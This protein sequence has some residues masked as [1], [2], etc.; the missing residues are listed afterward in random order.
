[1]VNRGGSVPAMVEKVACDGFVFGR[2]EGRGDWKEAIYG[3]RRRAGAR[4]REVLAP[5]VAAV[6]VGAG[7]EWA[8]GDFLHRLSFM[9]QGPKREIEIE[10]NSRIAADPGDRSRREVWNGRGPRGRRGDIGDPCRI[11]DFAMPG[12]KGG[13]IS[14][15][16]SL[17]N[18]G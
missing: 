18:E 6:E 12:G 8:R 1:M 2:R 15:S 3:V 14:Q 16:D 5:D 4:V 11:I 17:G 7:V 9:N 13:S 10:G